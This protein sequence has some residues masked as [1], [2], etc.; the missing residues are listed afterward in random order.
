MK[1]VLGQSRA[2]DILQAALRHDRLHHAYIFHGPAGVGKFT[3]AMAFAQVLLCHDR[4][5]DA[6]GDVVACGQCPSC[7]LLTESPKPAGND[8][9]APP[10]AAHPDL[11]VIAKEL[12]RYSQDKNIRDRKLTTIPFDVLRDTLVQRVYHTT[13]LRHGKVFIVDEAEL[14]T[15]QGQNILLKAL[16]EP[17]SQTYL[18][19]VTGNEDRLL[20]TIRSRCQRV[21]F[22]PLP[23]RAVGNW[24]ASRGHLAA[25]QGQ[26]LVSYAQG[27]LGRA[28]LAIEY[29]LSEWAGA[30]LPG[31][32]DAVRGQPPSD[33]GKQIA[34]RINGF[35]TAW[36]EA[37]ANAS[38][39][40]ANRQGAALMWSLIAQHAR[41]RIN[42]IAA[43][44]GT[45]TPGEIEERMEPWL[46]VIAALQKAEAELWANLNMG[47][48]CD[49]LV[50][51]M[52]GEACS[53]S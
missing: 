26:W 37:H 50:A 40:A 9:D 29:G 8:D 24:I 7:K 48:T 34:E 17:P 19:L 18:I 41:Q 4:R 20:A 45:L 23:D 11:H 47:L 13:Q 31:I 32:D 22:A 46:G 35:A 1:D 30:L 53:L 49:H 43:Q 38:K 25:G 33:L 28:L 14:I 36:V 27:S 12:A 16:E 42:E 15:P 3:T 44:T 6:A 39:E 10:A 51:M 21:A 52:A 5:T 2:I